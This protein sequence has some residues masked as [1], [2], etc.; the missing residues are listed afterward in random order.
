MRLNLDYYKQECDFELNSNEEKLIEYI[1][2]NEEKDFE[3]IVRKDL[4][5][6]TILGLSN[7]RKNLIYSYEFN[8]NSTVLEIGA[9]FGEI[10]GALCEKCAKV[11]SIELN[12]KRAEES[13]KKPKIELPK[14]EN[15]DIKKI[16]NDAFDC[17]IKGNNDKFFFNYQI[18]EQNKTSK[19]NIINL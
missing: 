5:D 17:F 16:I 13:E 8:P 6:D 3:D 10:T 19:Y 1:N 4:S 9:H 11:I 15:V 18:L 14:E 12:K 2:S 7:I